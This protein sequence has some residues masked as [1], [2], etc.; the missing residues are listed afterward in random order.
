MVKLDLKSVTPSRT[1]DNIEVF[2][3]VL[4]WQK[5][6]EIASLKVN[7]IGAGPNK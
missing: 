6:L 5:M 7:S 3:F 1:T 2:S 4:S